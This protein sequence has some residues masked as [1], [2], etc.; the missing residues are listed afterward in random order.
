VIRG[1]DRLSGA[2]VRAPDIRAGAALVL[3]G[4]CAEGRTDVYDEGHI[5]RGYEDFE[6][7]LI[8]LGASIEIRET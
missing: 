3:G 8:G 5:A 2:P 1:A 7:K 6:G 4:I